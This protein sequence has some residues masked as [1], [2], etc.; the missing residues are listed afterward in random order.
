[1]VLC[2]GVRS[3][4][5]A[6]TTYISYQTADRTSPTYSDIVA[7]TVNPVWDHSAEVHLS[8]ELLTQDSKVSFPRQNSLRLLLWRHR[9]LKLERQPIPKQTVRKAM[10]GK[11]LRWGGARMG[12]PVHVDTIYIRV[13]NNVLA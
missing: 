9:W 11:R 1:M 8:N 10:L 3:G 12:F 13:I 4:E 7:N 6:P 2:F 5:V